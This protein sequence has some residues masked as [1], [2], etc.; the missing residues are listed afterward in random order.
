MG[1]GLTYAQPKTY[2]VYS[3]PLEWKNLIAVTWDK[4]SQIFAISHLCA[5][6]EWT[7]PCNARLSACSLTH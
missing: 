4:N 2:S 5:T 7:A 1:L 3:D 6:P